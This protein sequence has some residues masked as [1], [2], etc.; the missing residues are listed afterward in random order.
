MRNVSIVIPAL[1]EA[2]GIEQTIRAIPKIELEDMGYEVQ[3]LVVD[4][5]SSDGTGEAA[6]RAGAE[7]VR[8]PRRGYGRA[9]KTGF[10]H[11]RMDI[12]ATVDADYSHPVEDLPK[13]IKMLDDEDLDFITTNR[14][15]F[16]SKSAMSP[17]H[18][19]GNAVL[20][21]AARILFGIKLK[22][23]QSG[24]WVFR[25]ELL[26]NLV[27]KS[28]SMSFSEELKIEVCHFLKCRWREVPIQ[29]RARVGTAKLR[30]WQDGFENL[31]FLVRRRFVGQ[32]L[33]E[34]YDTAVDAMTPS[35]PDRRG[36]RMMGIAGGSFDDGRATLLATLRRMWTWLAARRDLWNWLGIPWQWSRTRRFVWQHIAQRLE[37]GFH[38]Y[39]ARRLA[40]RFMAEASAL[41]GYFGYT[42]DQFVGK[43]VL[44]VGAGSQ[45]L[46]KFFRG[47]RIIAI[48]PLG[49]RFLR[50]LDW[51]E[52]RD[53]DE[54]YSVPA[55]QRI[56]N[57]VEGT[58]LAVSVNVL[59]HCF[60]PARVIANMYD[61]LRV[62]GKACISVDCHL[63]RD[64]VHPQPLSEGSLVDM[65][66]DTGFTIQQILRGLGGVYGSTR[67]GYGAGS[68]LTFILAKEGIRSAVT[69]PARP[70][71]G[72]TVGTLSHFG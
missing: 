29:C 22:D 56:E 54:V 39:Y 36:G 20:N 11:A 24:M 8:E 7:V 69:P 15:A 2:E 40:N 62:G 68:A 26:S 27:L 25:R 35:M 72:D 67:D 70:G 41:F 38:K 33:K 64:P 59:D 47:A 32:Q 34:V 43:V 12:I 66:R 31:M 46:T 14:Y 55:E 23:T 50:E 48:E 45:L 71:D 21:L 65:F 57:L 44:D 3:I 10:A 58:D 19:F 51:C 1:N 52:L 49:D 6:R 9:H 17:L 60:D 30:T 13:L 42:R 28:D 16:L 63:Y 5:G 61:Y 18:R 53:A 4:N 37:F